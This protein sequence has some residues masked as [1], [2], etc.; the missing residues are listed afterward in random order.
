MPASGLEKWAVSTPAHEAGRGQV[1]GRQW[2]P[3]TFMSGAQIPEADL[4]ID[5]GWI[6]DIPTPNPWEPEQVLDHDQLLLHIGMDSATPQDLGA[7]IE[8]YLGGQRVVFN[9]T[10]SVF[11]PKGTPYGPVTWKEVRRPHVQLS[12]VFGSGDPYASGPTAT[13]RPM[14]A[15]PAKTQNFDYEQYVIRSPMREAGPAYVEGRQNPTMTYLSRTQI[16]QV[17]NYLE[18]GWIWD[19]PKPPIPKMRHDSFDEVVLHIGSDP[20]APEALGGI[21]EF[22]IADELFEFDTTHCAYIPRGVNHGPLAWKKVR[23]PVIELALMLGAGTEQEGW[24]N[25]FFD[26]AEG[27]KRRSK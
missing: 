1:T 14:D 6:Y 11:I 2:P 18:F 23:R 27:I 10:T 8:F 12:I 15:V 3:M 13:G 26:D 19:V 25:S 4:H 17:N 21:L 16:N 24:A 20:H 22:G 5:L 9:T 7:V